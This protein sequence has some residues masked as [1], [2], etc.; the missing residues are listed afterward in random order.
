MRRDEILMCGRKFDWILMPFRA[1]G[2][3]QKWAPALS[4]DGSA[5]TQQQVDMC[6]PL[7]FSLPEEDRSIIEN[8]SED[9]R[10]CGHTTWIVL[11]NHYEDDCIYRRTKLLH[12]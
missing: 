10:T 5:S 6:S 1:F 12:D 3:M 11:V 7:I 4:S 9:G 8:V 2:L